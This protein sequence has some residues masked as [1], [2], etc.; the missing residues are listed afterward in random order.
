MRCGKERLN[1]IYIYFIVRA[2]TFLS[3]I[4]IVTFINA[5]RLSPARC[6]VS[7]VVCFDE[8]HTNKH[9]RRYRPDQQISKDRDTDE[10]S[11]A[12]VILALSLR[13]LNHAV[14]W[15][16]LKNITMD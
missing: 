12:D 14:S 4:F 13:K 9:W 8:A 5:L 16:G 3:S 10:G 6:R 15:L 1:Q 11:A 2:S 7:L